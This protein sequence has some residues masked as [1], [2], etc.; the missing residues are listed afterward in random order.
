[1]KKHSDRPYPA[2]AAQ[3]A[4]PDDLTRPGAPPRPASWKELQRSFSTLYKECDRMIRTASNADTYVFAGHAKAELGRMER[5]MD[6]I[7]RSQA[8]EKQLGLWE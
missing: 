6:K 4:Y 5:K 7:R 2:K 1:M 3:N 8:Q